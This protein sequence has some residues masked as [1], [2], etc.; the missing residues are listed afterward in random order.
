VEQV[1]GIILCGGQSSRMGR[2]KCWLP[3]GGEFMLPR[4]V[5]L[6]SEVL[7]PIVVVASP[8]Q[9]L[10]PLT[11]D[12]IVVSDPV[13][14]RGPLQGLNA[15][16]AALTNGTHGAERAYVSSCDA[17]FLRPAF[18]RRMVEL[19][20]EPDVCV[21]RVDGFL[22]PL[23]AV[24]RVEIAPVAQQLLNA[25]RSR[26]TDLF[27]AVRTRIVT[28]DELAEADPQLQSLRNLNTPEE[29]AAALL[30]LSN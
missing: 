16:L 5:R 24:Y 10:P 18:V 30:N 27:T 15:G 19:L 17:P 20:G 1:A 6:L 4:V 14:G 29:Y 25:G 9:E 12:E 22:H 28:A 21:P 7:S 26:L 23:A 8:G 2:P 3:V 11:G 13:R